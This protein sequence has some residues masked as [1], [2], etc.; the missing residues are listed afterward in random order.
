MN[1]F[2]SLDCL[3]AFAVIG[4][5]ICH[6]LS[7]ADLNLPE[8]FLF[9]KFL[10]FGSEYVFLF[11]MLSA[12]SMCCA[13]YQKFKDRQVDLNTFYK[14][15]YLR[16]WPFFALM[17]LIDVALGFSKESLI[18]AFADLTLFFGRKQANNRRLN[19]RDKRHVRISDNRIGRKIFRSKK[20][21][22]HKSLAAAA[23]AN[24][25]AA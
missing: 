4:V 18:E 22:S 9:Q 5:V 20:L 16:I 25:S 2:E 12:F 3:R 8:N 6:V 1:R 23:A 11:M 13:Y 7:N 19:N 10:P 24:A 21:T 17:V 14:R 15:R